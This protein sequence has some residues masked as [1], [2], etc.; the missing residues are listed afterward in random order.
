MKEA[1]EVFDDSDAHLL[2]VFICTTCGQT[3]NGFVGSPPM[4]HRRAMDLHINDDGEGYGSLDHI[5]W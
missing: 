5:H 2:R 4:C 1:S 3:K